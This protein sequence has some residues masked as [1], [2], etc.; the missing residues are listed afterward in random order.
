MVGMLATA[1]LLNYES[2]VNAVLFG[3]NHAIAVRAPWTHLFD[4]LIYGQ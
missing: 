3:G 2:N 1:R 4:H